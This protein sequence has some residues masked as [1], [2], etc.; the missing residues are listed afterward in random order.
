MA[1]RRP[2]TA[3]KRLPGAES[4]LQLSSS[5]WIRGVD[6]NIKRAV[7]ANQ[8]LSMRADYTPVDLR[9]LNGN[10]ERTQGFLKR[11]SDRRVGFA[12]GTSETRRCH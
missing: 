2:W 4:L 10:S 9:I 1:E 12:C 6:N 11:S 5:A 7:S 3:R 8:D